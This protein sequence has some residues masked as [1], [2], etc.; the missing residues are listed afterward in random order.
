MIQTKSL[1]RLWKIESV[2]AGLRYGHGKKTVNSIKRTFHKTANTSE[3]E[4]AQ[5]IIVVRKTIEWVYWVFGYPQET[6]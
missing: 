3:R 5:Q 1:V 2:S 4:N 6:I